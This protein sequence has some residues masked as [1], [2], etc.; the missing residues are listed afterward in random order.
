[1]IGRT[2]LRAL[3]L[4]VV[5]SAAA[6]L[7][8]AGLAALP[9]L[10]EPANLFLHA[11]YVV[12]WVLFCVASARAYQRAMD[13]RHRAADARLAATQSDRIAQ[14][15]GALAQARAP[16]AAI[17][18]ALQEPLHALHADAGL[19][20]LIGRGTSAD[21]VRTVGYRTEEREGR[22]APGGTK[23][24]AADAINRGAPV[25]IESLNAWKSEYAHLPRGPFEALAAVP[26][27]IGSRVFAVVQLEFRGPRR[28]SKAD[29]EYL[30][31]LGRTAAQA[32]D[33]TWEYEGAL[34]ARA[35]ADELR[36]RAEK[37]LVERLSVERA[38]RASEARYRTLVARTTRLHDLAS[39]LSEAASLHA[40]AR[41][42]VQHGKNVLGAASGEIEML[43]DDGAA[44][45]T[46]FSDA[47]GLSNEREPVAPGLCATEAVRTR[48]PVFVTSFDQWQESYARSAALAADGGYVSS[49]TLP[50]VVAGTVAGVLAFHF[51]APV[52]FDDDYRD[53]LESVARHCGQAME[54]ARLYEAADVARAAAELANRQKDEF[55][56]IVSHELRT[57]INAILGW[58]SMLQDHLLDEE[59]TKRA[60]QSIT[61][62]ANRQVRL[63]EDL[64]DFSRLQ[65]GRMKLEFEDVDLSEVMR[66]VGESMFPV[67]KAA[68]LQLEMSP[69][70]SAVVR[71]DAR[72]LEQVFLNLLGNAVK[73]TPEKGRVGV[74]VTT[75]GEHVEIRVSDTGP[76][77][78][79]EF[80][81]HLFEAFSQAGETS[82]R[83]YGG[84]GLGL[85]IAKEL[86]EAHSGRIAAESAG[87]GRGATFL[88][89]LPV[90]RQAAAVG[91]DDDWKEKSP[92][93]PH[94]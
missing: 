64:L 36:I 13:D 71:G 25:L 88:V 78:D 76:G 14:L 16:S 52:N 40:V 73:F 63:V 92:G 7:F 34:S 6:W 10:S 72:R 74:E 28:F 2:L 93:Q 58:T 84:V 19:V 51:T 11:A 15:T 89:T 62:N 24:P 30:D 80:V 45:E 83:R 17:E 46:V 9:H 85:S 75:D 47:R 79:P 33:R 55:V 67:A 12:A 66:R 37:E 21:V 5:L 56:S 48:Q 41:A 3:V 82:G 20:M 26:L 53:L 8:L 91:G 23:T 18:A 49:A 69:L 4:V 94:L 86:V 65:S 27:L 32:L 90:S 54:R 39:A 57:P 60:L 29:R 77:I 68:G 1:M 35:E 42:V 44:F 43:V 70:P 61:D 38:L 87:V 31:A 22:T 50:I 81:P 59:G